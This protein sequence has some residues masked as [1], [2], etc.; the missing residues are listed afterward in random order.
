MVE[1]VERVGGGVGK[2]RQMSQYG[3]SMPGSTMASR[4]PGM[5]VYTGLLT[6]AVC[7]LLAACVI[8]AMQGT[9]LSPD[10]GLFSVQPD[11]TKPENASAEIKFAK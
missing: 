8:V 1:L 10:G 9:K 6:L 2:E 11:T 5:T 7:A 3:M 4:R